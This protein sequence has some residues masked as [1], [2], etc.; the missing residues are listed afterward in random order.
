MDESMITFGPVASRRLGSSLGINNIRPKVCTYSCVYCQVGRTLQMECRPRYFFEPAEIHA[1]TARRLAALH[2]QGGAVDC[3]TFVPDGEPT[4]DSRIGVAIEQLQ[5]LGMKIGIITN[6]S[7]LWRPE[8]RQAVAKA[9]WVSVKVDSVDPRC[10]R[11]INRPHPQLRLEEVLQGIK[12]FARDF[13]GELVTET[14]LVAG[15]NDKPADIGAVANFLAEIQPAKAYL[16]APIRPPAEKWVR[17]PEESVMAAAH[18]LF[19]EKLAR[20]EYLLGFKESCTVAGDNLAEELLGITAVHP[21]REETVSSL[22]KGRK[23]GRQVLNELLA[24]KQLVIVEYAGHRF[25]VRKIQEEGFSMERKL[26]SEKELLCFL[27][28]ELKK[29]GQHEDC[30][31]DSIIRMKIEDRTGCN[32]ASATIQCR[33]G[34]GNICPTD[35]ER[36]VTGAKTRFNIA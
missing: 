9:Q 31:F 33:E 35:A 24:R 32:W 17:A 34:I 14:M 3:L 15:L 36:I 8:V 5:G 30:R 27:N 2:R 20:V 11:R 21:L 6:G 4:L 7:L 10:W 13:A 22:L 16:A 19:K 12:A 1:Q 23:N 25:W 26:V 29:T 28:Q 18:E